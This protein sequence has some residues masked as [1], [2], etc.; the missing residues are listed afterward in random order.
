MALVRQATDKAI[1]SVSSESPMPKLGRSMTDTSLGLKKQKSISQRA[2]ALEKAICNCIDAIDPDVYKS[3]RTEKEP[4]L[5]M[6]AI[7][8]AVMLIIKG[9][10][11]NKED[12]FKALS[13]LY[14][15]QLQHAI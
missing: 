10:V 15:S 1:A 9:S 6:N 4:T 12:S 11:M 7:A 5:I 2:Y 3:L 13:K 14:L 8:E